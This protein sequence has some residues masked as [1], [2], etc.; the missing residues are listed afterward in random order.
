MSA[1][2]LSRWSQRKQGLEVSSPDADQPLAVPEESAVEAASE[3]PAAEL[4]LTDADMPDLESLDADSDVSMF[5]AKGVSQALRQKALRQLFHQPVYNTISEL[6]EYIEDYTQLQ[7]LSSETAKRMQS[8]V[9]NQLDE[10]L[11]ASNETAGQDKANTPAD[12]QTTLNKDN[13]DDDEPS[14]QPS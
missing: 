2:F 9:K 10:W 3:S 1:S 7:P 14:T 6:D 5:F 4:E 13:T 11:E 8:L 12:A